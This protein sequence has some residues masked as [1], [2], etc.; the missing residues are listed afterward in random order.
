MNGPG[1]RV[2][3]VRG[4]RASQGDATVSLPVPIFQAPPT[5]PMP[6]Y[7]TNAQIGVRFRF[8]AD[9]PVAFL[10]APFVVAVAE[11]DLPAPEGDAWEEGVGHA[12]PLPEGWRPTLADRTGMRPTG[13]FVAEEVRPDGSA[14]GT[15]VVAVF[16]LN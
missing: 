3:T 12:V 11:A 4:C 10:V 15:L 2:S 6:E 8:G 14:R 13:A 16:G 1:G 9:G 7:R 5:A